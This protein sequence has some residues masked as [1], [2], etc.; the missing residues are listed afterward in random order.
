[1]TGISQI[2]NGNG[3][4]GSGPTD[5]R[6]V[7]G[8][9]TTGPTQTSAT[10]SFRITGSGTF[11]AGFSLDDF[12]FSPTTIQPPTVTAA[13]DQPATEG[14]S[15]A[16]DLGSFSDP[17][18]GPWN[19]DVNWGDNT[20]DTK[21]QV[22]TAGPLGT[23]NHTYAEESGTGTAFPVT[24]TVTDSTSLSDSKTFNVTVADAA[25]TQGAVSA[26]VVIGGG[27]PTSLSAAFTD[28]NTAA[29]LSDFSGTI[30]WGD[31]SPAQSFTS[32]AVSGGGGSYSVGG[33]HLYAGPGTYTVNVTINDAG[34]SSTGESTTTAVIGPGAT[35]FGG[36]LYMVGGNTNDQLNVTPTGTSSTGSS[37]ISVTGKLNGNN[38]NTSYN[39]AFTTIYVVGYDG[40][41]NFKFAGTMTISAVVSDG[42]GNDNIQLGNGNNTVVAGNGN[43]NVQAGDGNNTITLGTGNDVIK[44]GN[45]TNTVT[46]GA[47]GSTAG[48]LVQLGDGNNNSVQLLG[49]GND[50][51]QV[52][53]GT[54]GF[55]SIVG[56]GNNSV[57]TGT[58]TGLV[59]LAGT[60]K[61]TLDLGGG[62][63]LI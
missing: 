47:A 8:S 25:L 31:G 9:Y 5:F 48:I 55:V 46:A 62:W 1:M 49:D 44:A 39:Q 13:A 63:S 7:Y 3:G 19:V 22:A 33:S 34:G 50:Q 10:V 2:V 6:H 54:G 15:Q 16:F 18:G 52:G 37:G 17:D 36:A 57:K 29:P 24:V 42:N 21:F 26:P 61:Q 59:H 23:Q 35:P 51:V 43:D 11:R 28:A 4:V 45:G 27:I 14:A 38:I 60:G 58:G 56:N 20:P 40:N 32:G 53:N 12:G 41:D 30:D